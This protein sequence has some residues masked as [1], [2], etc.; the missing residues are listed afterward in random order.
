MSASQCTA[1]RRFDPNASCQIQHVAKWT[2]P[3]PTKDSSHGVS[4]Q[5][6]GCFNGDVWYDDYYTDWAITYTLELYTTFHYNGGCGQPT[7]VGPYCTIK[8][9]PVIITDQQCYYWHSNEFNAT[10]GKQTVFVGAIWV[11]YT[12]GQYR[13]CRPD[14]TCYWG[15]I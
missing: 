3:I 15:Y 11:G 1:A 14:V 2:D 6:P 10:E 8:W 13:G 4:P 9:T 12:A 7:G 5:Y